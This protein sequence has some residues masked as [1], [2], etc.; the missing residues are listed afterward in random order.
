MNIENIGVAPPQTAIGGEDN[1]APTLS[2][3]QEAQSSSNFTT[4]SEL[5]SL[6]KV[7]Q[8]TS[9]ESNFSSN[10]RVG[11]DRFDYGSTPPGEAEL[12]YEGIEEDY[13][14]AAVPTPKEAGELVE[15]GL[16][17]VFTAPWQEQLDAAV[18]RNGGLGNV[19]D[20]FLAF[21]KIGFVRLRNENLTVEQN[22]KL[23]AISLQLGTAI[24]NMPARA[25]ESIVENP[26][27]NRWVNEFIHRF[28]NEFDA[29]LQDPANDVQ[30]IDGRR[31]FVLKIDEQ[32]GIPVSYYYKKHGG[33]TGWVQKNLEWLSPVLDGISTLAAFIPG[34]G[35]IV[36]A[37]T[38]VAKAGINLAASGS[39]KLRALLG[40]ATSLFGN[41]FPGLSNLA[42]AGLSLAS[43]AIGRGK[44]TPQDVS[45]ALSF[46]ALE[47]KDKPNP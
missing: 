43:Q 38:Q 30:V 36:S 35:P 46:A 24:E 13:L 5:S 2:K 28:D 32:S 12:L 10:I 7:Q 15:G 23:A 1:Q 41:L 16:A 18:R 9:R 17:N 19:E 47:I 14:V 8:K 42:R 37:V 29:F 22:S 6:A 27:I 20:G 31:R 3:N 40:S 26:D 25:D 34:V 44:I 4:L 33:F 11:L 21:S 39:L 45:A